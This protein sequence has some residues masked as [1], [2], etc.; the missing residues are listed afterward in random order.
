MRREFL[1]GSIHYN[2][3]IAINPSDHKTNKQ[4]VDFIEGKL[5]FFLVF[6][7]TNCYHRYTGPISLIQ[8]RQRSFFKIVLTQIRFKVLSYKALVVAGTCQIWPCLLN[9]CEG[10]KHNAPLQSNLAYKMCTFYYIRF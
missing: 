10:R 9:F 3:T 4:T 5:T 2:I 8:K 1:I 7:Q 6:S